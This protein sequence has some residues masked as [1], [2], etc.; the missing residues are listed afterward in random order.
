MGG[1]FQDEDCNT[2]YFTWHDWMFVLGIKWKEDVL[3]SLWHLKDNSAALCPSSSSVMTTFGRQTWHR[4]SP[5]GTTN[6]SRQTIRRFKKWQDKTSSEHTPAFHFLF[7]FRPTL[8]YFSEEGWK[9]VKR[10]NSRWRWL[11]KSVWLARRH[12]TDSQQEQR[13]VTRAALFRLCLDKLDKASRVSSH[14]RPANSLLTDNDF[15]MAGSEGSG[16][17]I[18]L[19]VCFSVLLFEPSMRAELEKQTLPTQNDANLQ[20]QHGGGDG[21]VGVWR[22]RLIIRS[23]LTDA[24][25]RSSH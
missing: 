13:A 18:A 17:S 19:H 8:L 22:R 20:Q 16:S 24:P 5:D 2:C 12:K 3:D 4:C 25:G 21:G 7:S 15:R 10:G 11:I 6:T 23:P 1:C 14:K 9:Q